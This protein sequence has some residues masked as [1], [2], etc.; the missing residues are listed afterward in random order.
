MPSNS[1]VQREGKGRAVPRSLLP[2]GGPHCLSTSLRSWN[3]PTA[4]QVGA[5]QLLLVSDNAPALENSTD[6]QDTLNPTVWH[7]ASLQ[8]I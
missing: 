6:I 2:P 8:L 3:S 4:A 1:C 5:A 7:R